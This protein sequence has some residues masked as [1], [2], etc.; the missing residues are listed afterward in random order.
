MPPDDFGH[1]QQFQRAING[2]DLGALG[3]PERWGGAGEVSLVIPAF[4]ATRLEAVGPQIIR[5]QTADL[6]ARSWDWSCEWSID[7][8][9]N[10]G[11]IFGAI[12]GL[13]LTWG[14]GQT[15]QSGLIQ[16]G[17]NTFAGAGFFA[18]FIPVE[19]DGGGNIAGAVAA[20]PWPIPCVS[21]AIVPIVRIDSYGGP[22]PTSLRLRASVT[23][24]PRALTQ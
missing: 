16:L 22:V 18:G 11:E 10:F 14:A 12:A 7:C 2:R 6:I 15:S 1:G 8:P 9:N 3:D 21:L 4:A 24:A 23:V 5:V 19:T 13:R 20:G 17:Q